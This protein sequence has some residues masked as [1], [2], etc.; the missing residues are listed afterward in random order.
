[1]LN[2]EINKCD[3][4]SELKIAITKCFERQAS[5]WKSQFSSNPR[6]PYVATDDIF[7]IKN[8]I[9][10][11]GYAEWKTLSQTMNIETEVIEKILGV[12]LHS[13]LKDYYSSYGFMQLIGKLSDEI[14]IDFIKIPFGVS[15]NYIAEK[16][17]NT[18]VMKKYGIDYEKY[19]LFEIGYATVEGNDG[20][21]TCVDNN[22]GNVLLIHLVDQIVCE[23]NLTLSDLFNSFVE[24]Y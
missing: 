4:S 2:T 18:N 10:E 22:T 6:F 13:Q 12:K 3:S 16:H 1:M 23:L 17:I 9:D 14:I 5:F 21:L 8:T 7:F 15:S 19:D 24:V 20:Y 11:E